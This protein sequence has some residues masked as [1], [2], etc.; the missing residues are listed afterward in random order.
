MRNRLKQL[1]IEVPIVPGGAISEDRL[2]RYTYLRYDSVAAENASV[3]AEIAKVHAEQA[4]KA[5]ANGGSGSDDLVVAEKLRATQSLGTSYET[6]LRNNP[7]RVPL[8]SVADQ[9]IWGVQEAYFR[10]DC[11][12]CCGGG[13]GGGGAGSSA[14]NAD[15]WR[16]FLTL[17]KIPFTLIS[18]AS[19]TVMCA[20][21]TIYRKVLG[22]LADMTRLEWLE[23]GLYIVLMGCLS[24]GMV[25]F[26]FQII[27]TYAGEYRRARTL[28][29][30]FSKHICQS[31]YCPTD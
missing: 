17:D 30:C 22:Q 27:D 20:L 6:H 12:S 19:M 29:F 9:I 28:T 5:N 31:M 7:D 16:R 23:A 26:F 8:E 4:A 10:C 18:L 14:N 25:A 15:W 2:S 24:V 21:P 11:C 3:E 13:G 1:H